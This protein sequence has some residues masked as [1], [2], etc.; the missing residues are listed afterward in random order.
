MQGHLLAAIVGDAES[1]LRFD[2]IQHA[3]WQR[4]VNENTNGP[5][6]QFLPE[7]EDLSVYSQL[8]LDRYAW[9][10]NARPR[11][12]LGWKFPAELFLPDF[13]FVNT[14]QSSLHFDVKTG[15]SFSMSPRGFRPSSVFDPRS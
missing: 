5:I 10:L 11:K 8:E 3:P 1:F 13:D 12:S 4:G 9:L 14:T 6:R 7:G 2:P 15:Y